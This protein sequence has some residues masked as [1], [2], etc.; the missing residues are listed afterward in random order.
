MNARQ[1]LAFVVAVATLRCATSTPATRE[2][3]GAPAAPVLPAV[4]ESAPAAVVVQPARDIEGALVLV[5]AGRVIQRERGEGGA[6]DAIRT[7][8]EAL[9]ADP[10]CAAALWELGWSYQ[11][12]AELD[13]AVAAWDE[14][15][16][17]E[18][19]Y[20][21]LDRHYPVLLMRRDQ[22]RAL[23]ALPDPGVLPERET[24]PRE[25]PTLT[26]KA[27]GDVNL[28]RAW[29][30]D[31]ATLPA[32]DA[33]DLFVP[34]AEELKAADLTI[35]NLET[36]LADSGDSTKCGPKSTKCFSFRVPTSYAAALKEA[37]FDIMGIAN[38]HAG[39]FGQEGR[40]ATKQALDA[41]GI[42]YSGTIGDVAS[43]EINGLRLALI[44]FSFGADVYSILDIPTAKRVVADLKRRHDLV[45]V[46]F[47]GGA[48]GADAGHVPKEV[49][50]FLGENRGD[51]YGFAHGVVDAGADLVVGHGPHRV[52]GVE[53]YKGRFIA[54][55]LGN[56]CTYKMFGLAGALGVTAVLGV[57]LAANG[58]VTEARLV[59]G[60]IDQPGIPRPDPTGQAIK[61]VRDLSR[62]DF[63]DAVLDAAGHYQRSAPAAATASS[64]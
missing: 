55:S 48:E 32:N 64:P 8:R 23:A 49:E 21:D 36:V 12:Q 43:V 46:S 19:G 54:Y 51:E 35:G 29:P 27:V 31:R 33:R 50:R 47:H 3:V 13:Q 5:E 2:P 26:L 22:A 30:A 41:V 45:V 52:R 10:K 61:L 6:A 14:L 25:G 62:Q 7:Y 9:A 4:A 11:V 17:L 59:P 34:F 63:G 39:D 60:I 24:A 58:V 18:P 16:A 28:G 56:F 44:A 53:I 42:K 37:G 15:K 20:P 57:T 40:A 38:N 1:P